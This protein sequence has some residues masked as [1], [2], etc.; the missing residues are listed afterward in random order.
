MTAR[1]A[2]LALADRHKLFF[3]YFVR[4]R[5]EKD[6]REKAAQAAGYS[7]SR[8]RQTAAA[9]AAREDFKA[10]LAE[11]QSAAIERN[12]I[13]IDNVIAELA[14]IGFANMMDFIRIG[15]DGEPVTDFTALTRDKAAAIKKVVVTT[16]RELGAGEGADEDEKPL[17]TVRKVTFELADKRAALVDIG[18][19]LGGFVSRT[20]VGK[21]GEFA[22]MTDDELRAEV[23]KEA[24]ELG[25]TA[26]KKGK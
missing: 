15:P 6:V 21:P 12:D 17:V 4:H 19:H 10:A 14:K 8:L 16:E 23:E 13:T 18:R 1:P 20:E 22:A 7:G 25:L 5:T 11:H 2:Y 3:D 24:R 9:I 26:A